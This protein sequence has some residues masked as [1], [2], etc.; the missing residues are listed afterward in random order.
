MEFDNFYRGIDEGVDADNYDF[1]HP[2]SLDFDSVHGCLKSL[3]EMKVTD[4]PVYCFKMH[5]RKQNEHHTIQP[6]NF[7]ILEGILAFYDERIRDL[8]DVKI[9]IHCDADIALARRVLRDIS[10]RGRDAREVIARYNKFVRDD[11]NNFVKPYMK[12]ADIIIPGGADNNIGVKFI[13]DNLKNHRK[14]L[15]SDESNNSGRVNIVEKL[16]ISEQEMRRKVRNGVY[17]SFDP[18]N[19]HSSLM[20]EG[21]IL[22]HTAPFFETAISYWEKRTIEKIRTRL[23]EDFQSPFEELKSQIAFM[24]LSEFLMETKDIDPTSSIRATVIYEPFFFNRKLDLVYEQLSKK[25]RKLTKSVYFVS[26]MNEESMVLKLISLTPM[27]RIM[28]L[29]S[30]FSEDELFKNIK[31]DEHGGSVD[32]STIRQVF[33]LVNSS[34]FLEQLRA[35]PSTIKGTPAKIDTEISQD[36]S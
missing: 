33:R 27:I 26:L 11:F 10:E 9:F 18:T 8:L 29:F 17:Y 1:D 22:K 7:V 21:L 15:N 16:V 28:M 32:E 6:K 36:A 5:K 35:T 2:E 13:V 14:S 23:E 4:T 31:I 25:A 30:V 3:T 34:A 20:I 19:S 12:Y 24:P